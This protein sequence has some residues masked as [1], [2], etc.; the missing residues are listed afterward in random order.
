MT[1]AYDMNVSLDHIGENLKEFKPAFGRVEKIDSG[2]IFLIK[3][4]TSATEVL[5]TIVPNI[6]KNDRILIALN[7]NFADG[8]DISWIWDAEFEMLINWSSRAKRG[9]RIDEKK[10]ATSPQTPRNDAHII[11]SGSRAHDMALRLKYAGITPDHIII[12]PSIKQA[13]EEARR[14]LSALPAGRQGTLYVLPT[15]TALLE[16]QHLL[17]KQGAKKEYWKEDHE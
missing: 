4:P 15:Y 13:L 11:T 16:L 5:S 9:D 8:K 14:S 3:N 10:I 2:Y 12:Q 6:K 7:D 17:A 1:I